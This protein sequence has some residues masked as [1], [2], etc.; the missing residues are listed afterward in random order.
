MKPSASHKEIDP[1]GQKSESPILLQELDPEFI[2]Q[3]RRR[4]KKQ[5]NATL[6]KENQK[7][8]S[9]AVAALQPR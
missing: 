1:N 8:G 7:D 9:E 2:D 5:Q 3:N 6:E 4:G